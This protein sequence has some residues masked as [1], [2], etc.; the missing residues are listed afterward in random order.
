MADLMTRVVQSPAIITGQANELVVT[1]HRLV[2]LLKGAHKAEARELAQILMA[3][4]D[5]AG[6]LIEATRPGRLRHPRALATT[7]LTAIAA[8][9]S[10]TP[11][12][13]SATV[14]ALW[15]ESY[16]VST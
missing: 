15:A 13:D 14:Q 11:C 10:T 16:K 4:F 8:L 7:D 3:W 5:L 6:L 12:P 1:K 9:L 2:A